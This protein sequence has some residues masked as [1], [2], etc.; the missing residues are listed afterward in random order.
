[1]ALYGY[2]LELRFDAEDTATKGEIPAA[3][4]R[5]IRLQELRNRLKEEL[6]KS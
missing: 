1:M 4:D 6:L 3:K 2:N 5:I